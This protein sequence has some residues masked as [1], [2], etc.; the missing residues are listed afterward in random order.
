MSLSR[1]HSGQTAAVQIRDFY[2]CSP[3]SPSGRRFP[4]SAILV[5]CALILAGCGHHKS[6]VE[7]TTDSGLKYVDEV[8][9]TGEKARLGKTVVVHYTG[10]LTD[11]TK[12][13]SSRDKGQPYEFR[14]GAGSVIQGWEEGILSMHVGGKRRLIVPPDLGYG[15]RGKGQIPP[16]A[17]L[18]F[19]IELLGVK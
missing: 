16:N 9:G 10:T 17:T 1:Q 3:H 7:V 11:G 19:E 6:G 8:V 4:L 18:F 2:T 12:F 15:A 5:G 14:L 13:D